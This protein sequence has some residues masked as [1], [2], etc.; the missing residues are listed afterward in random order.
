[1]EAVLGREVEKRVVSKLDELDAYLRGIGLED[2]LSEIV[3]H[4]SALVRQRTVKDQYTPKEVAEI[5]GKQEFTVREWCR[6]G[7]I[8]ATKRPGGR[9]NEGEWR[10]SHEELLRYQNEGLLPRGKY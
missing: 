3:A 5:V 1:M 10:I 4:L 8:N 7:R 9:G 6:L 2:R